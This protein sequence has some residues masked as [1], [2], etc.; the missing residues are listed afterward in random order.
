M[1]IKLFK[2]FKDTTLDKNNSEYD[3]YYNEYIDDDDPSKAAMWMAE[4]SQERNFKIVSKNIKNNESVLDYGCGTGDFIS[5]LNS[6]DIIVSEYLGVD[7]NEN[8]INNAIE[9]HSEYDYMKIE[10]VNEISGHYDNVVSIGVFSLYIERDEFI[11]AINN[12]CEIANKQ[13]LITC[14]YGK[15][16]D[17]DYYWKKEYRFYNEK[18]FNKL[19]PDLNIEYVY[20]KEYDEE[21]DEYDILM[22][23]RIKK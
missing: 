16:N 23:V 2:E 3:L 7:I 19:F 9:N 22:L 18:I 21:Y 17:T 4:G 6:N 13:V 11:R 8:F 12:L 14:N 1:K 15:F 10:D 5:Y 20:D